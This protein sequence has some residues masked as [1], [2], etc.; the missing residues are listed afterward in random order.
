MGAADLPSGRHRLGA[1]QRDGRLDQ[2]AAVDLD[3]SVVQA[4]GFEHVLAEVLARHAAARCRDSVPPTLS[5]H[6]AG[7][8]HAELAPAARVEPGRSPTVATGRGE[9]VVQADHHVGDAGVLA[10]S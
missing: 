9:V 6:V 2:R 1:H 3:T 4:G 5:C 7:A 10:R 8:E